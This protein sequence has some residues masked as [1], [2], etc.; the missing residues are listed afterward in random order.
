MFESLLAAIVI[1][2]ILAA[3][4]WWSMPPKDALPRA[5]KPPS[6]K[7]PPR[8][9]LSSECGRAM[10]STALPRAS[11]ANPC[12]SGWKGISVI[13]R[14]SLLLLTAVLAGCAAKPPIIIDASCVSFTVIRPSRADTDET[15]RQILAHNQTWR[16][17]C[18]E[19]P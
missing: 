16:A 13:K 15:L 6:G 19:Q 4:L 2:A 7:L 18:A 17:L 14:L 8:K 11:I 10:T 3:I 12:I 5:W 9:R 1:I